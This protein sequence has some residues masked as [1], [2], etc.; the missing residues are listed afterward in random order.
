[1]CAA[2]AQSSRN[3]RADESRASGNYYSFHNHGT[4]D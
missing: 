1:V 2:G 4:K 3:I